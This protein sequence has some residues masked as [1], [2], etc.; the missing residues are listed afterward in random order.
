MSPPIKGLLQTT[1]APIA[2]D[3]QI[4]RL[5]PWLFAMDRGEGLDEADRDGVLP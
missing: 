1:I 4:G 3:W 2:S 5:S